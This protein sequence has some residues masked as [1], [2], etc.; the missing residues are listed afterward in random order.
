MGLVFL[1]QLIASAF[2]THVHHENALLRDPGFT[3]HAVLILLAYTAMSLSFLYAVLYLVQA[4]Q[5]SRRSFGLLFHRL[6]PLETLERM[7]VGAARLGVPLLFA[8]LAAGHLWMYDLRDRL[9]ADLAADLSPFDPKIIMS[10]VI[11]LGYAV[12]LIG[13]AR[14]GWRGRRMNR[15]A[16]VVWVLVVLAMGWCGTSYPAST[17]S[18]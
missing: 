13:H 14:W 8:S 15:V 7:S 16:I 17:T 4:R 5:L 11:F 2:T 10:W 3:G 9:P 1:M 12:G 6:P 18:R